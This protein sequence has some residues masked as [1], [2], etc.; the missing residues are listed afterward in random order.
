MFLKNLLTI[1]TNGLS[2]MTEARDPET[3]NH[4]KRMSL[5]SQIIAA[6]LLEK[7]AYMSV[8]DKSFVENILICAPMHDIGKA[9]IPD[10]ILLKPGKLTDEE[11]EIM[12]THALKGYEVLIHIDQ[13]FRRFNVNYFS[14]AAQIA[15]GA[16]G[17]I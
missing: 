6:R 2:E 12:K 10:D 7:E 1:V 4:L 14:V 8:I 11:Y 9:S 3:G 17:K 13:D 16:S 15:L 5:Y